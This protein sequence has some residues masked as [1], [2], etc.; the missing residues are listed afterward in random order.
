MPI[1][2]FL[3]IR[4]PLSLLVL[5][6]ICLFFFG[7]KIEVVS[8]PQS[9]EVG[10]TVEFKLRV[11]YTDVNGGSGL[12][13]F[14]SQVPAGWTLMSA[15]YEESTTSSESGLL[16][17]TLVN[18]ICANLDVAPGYQSLIL[19]PSPATGASNGD[20]AIVRL[21]FHINSNPEGVYRTW[22]QGFGVQFCSNLLVNSWG[23]T[24]PPTYRIGDTQLLPPGRPQVT[25]RAIGDFIYVATHQRLLTYRQENDG[26]LSFEGEVDGSSHPEWGLKYCWDVA[27]RMRDNASSIYLACPSWTPFFRHEAPYTSLPTFVESE[28]HQHSDFGNII[29]S[30]PNGNLFANAGFSTLFSTS[31]NGEIS[32]LRRIPISSRIA[33]SSDEIFAYLLVNAVVHVDDIRTDPTTRVQTITENDVP[34]EFEHISDL[35]LSP[36]G[37]YLYVLV[38]NLYSSTEINSSIVVFDRD[39]SSGMLTYQSTV[40]NTDDPHTLG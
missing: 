9:I 22:F 17:P 7:C 15:V 39:L 34:T 35:A 14:S 6:A 29:M 33:L 31:E 37:R 32:S 24:E 10:Q 4:K 18:N 5:G 36:N 30:S 23:Q 16:V 40:D 8:I 2:R 20:T 27:G 12:F 13:Y 25:P 38:D 19:T 1:T 28:L 21:T 11:T 26:S 3:Q